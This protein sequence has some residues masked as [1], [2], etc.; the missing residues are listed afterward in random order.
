MCGIEAPNRVQNPH[1]LSGMFSNH[2][3]VY[4]VML[5]CFQ[6]H[7]VPRRLLAAAPRFSAEHKL[8]PML[9]WTRHPTSWR[10]APCK[11]LKSRHIGLPR[12]W[13]YRDLPE[14]PACEIRIPLNGPC[15][16]T[17]RA[18]VWAACQNPRSKCRP[19]APGRQCSP[20]A[21]HARQA[22]AATR[23]HLT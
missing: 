19:G 11:A 6:P 9:M 16:T 4:Q 10:G 5:L 18:S 13:D 21:W 15:T 23:S 1:Q 7:T 8:T 12:S 2:P 22:E 3:Q 17:W 20:N 14:P